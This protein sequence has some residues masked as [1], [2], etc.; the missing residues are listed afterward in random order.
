MVAKIASGLLLSSEDDEVSTF[1]LALFFRFFEPFSRFLVHQKTHVILDDLV[2][3]QLF[4]VQASF[5]KGMQSTRQSC[6]FF[7]QSCS[8]LSLLD[9]EEVEAAEEPLEAD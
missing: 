3:L 5:C 1:F 4:Q 7:G 9:V 2:F 8:L 6:P